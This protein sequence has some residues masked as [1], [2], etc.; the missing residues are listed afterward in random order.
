MRSASL[1]TISPK[2]PIA[3]VFL[4]LA[5]TERAAHSASEYVANSLVPLDIMGVRGEKRRSIL[6]HLSSIMQLFDP[7]SQKRFLTCFLTDRL[8]PPV[9]D[10]HIGALMEWDETMVQVSRLL[11]DPL[12]GRFLAMRPVPAR[13]VFSLSRE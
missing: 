9:A 3:A 11:D 5:L 6:E 8:Y 10:E 1:V 12:Y 2:L 7:P 4:F 13:P